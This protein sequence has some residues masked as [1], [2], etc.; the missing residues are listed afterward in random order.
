MN[1]PYDIIKFN[2]IDD[3]LKLLRTKL[4]VVACLYKMQYSTIKLLARTKQ[5]S[6][7]CVRELTTATEWPPLV[8]EV[9][10]NCC[11]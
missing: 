7:A 10:I 1:F 8:G 3:I 9:S 6:V 2:F 5:N 4:Y 11:G